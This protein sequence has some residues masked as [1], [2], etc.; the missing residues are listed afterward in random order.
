VNAPDGN[1]EKPS[2]RIGKAALVVSAG[3]LLSRVL[4]ML[5]NVALA[6]LLGNTAEG[7]AFQAAFV[8]PDVLFYLM[9]GGYLTVTFIPILTRH[10]VQG[11]PAEGYRAFSAVF[12]PVAIAMVLLT[13]LAMIFAGSLT[14]LV[15]PRFD[16]QQAGEVTRLT[17][18]VLPA[19]IFFVLGSLWMAVQYAHQRFAI[20]AVAPVIY[21]LGIIIGGLLAWAVGSASAAGFA[22]GAVGGAFVGNFALQWY[23]ARRT[24]LRWVKGVPLRHPA[25]REYLVLAL[26]LMLGQSIAVLDE[27]FVRL[28]GQ[29][30]EEGGISALTYARRLNMLP[31]G[32]IAQTAGVAA[33]PFLAR[34][35]EEGKLK[36]MAA[37]V[38]RTIR[39]TIFISA[40]AVAAILALS[41]PSVR[42]VYERG[43]FGSQDTI[44]TA[45]ALV[46]YGLS[47]PAW[48]AHQIYARAF[49]ARR[50][51]WTPVIIGTA[52]TLVAIGGYWW[53]S[54]Y[55]EPGFALASTLA[56][57]LY[58]IALA[59][60][61]HARAG[62][63]GVSEILGSL[64]RSTVGAAVAAPIAWLVVKWISGGELPGFWGSLGLVGVGAAVVVL[65]YAAMA[66][67][68]RAPE[69]T[70]LRRRFAS[71]ASG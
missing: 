57:A 20:P 68:L 56:I 46:F 41:Q 10:L 31:V 39:Y 55:D 49:Y 11:D 36:E 62:S 17:R 28:F 35:V 52:G 42:V 25:V 12:R 65:V 50:Q 5:R 1:P 69:L 40:P 15:Y 14:D 8:I 60:A 26:P 53:L 24:G 47:I 29:L 6:G 70:D 38:A 22:W 66:R 45:T 48:G 13:I 3:I 16:A 9:A 37:T 23:G 58:T 51:M 2:G 18:I 19:Q 7:D 71:D 67:L 59:V 27:Q 30:T 61:W 33:Y 63:Q 43:E 34:L 4:G 32:V 64:V 21:N 44:L 54:R